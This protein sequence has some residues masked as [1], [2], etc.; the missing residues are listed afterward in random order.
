MSSNAASCLKLSYIHIENIPFI[1]MGKCFS[2]TVNGKERIDIKFQRKT[3]TQ[4]LFHMFIELHEPAFV[5]DF[6][7]FFQ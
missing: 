2:V 6:V 7:L 5:S 3:L 1:R 4:D